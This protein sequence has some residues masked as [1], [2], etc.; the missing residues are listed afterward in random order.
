MVSEKLGN[1]AAKLARCSLNGILL[2]EISDWMPEYS[3]QCRSK[4]LSHMLI[5]P[6]S[7]WYVVA[8][9]LFVMPDWTQHFWFWWIDSWQNFLQNN[10]RYKTQKRAVVFKSLSRR[11]FTSWRVQHANQTY[12]FESLCWPNKNILS[13]HCSNNVTLRRSLY[14]NKHNLNQVLHEI[15]GPII[16]CDIGWRDK[17]LVRNVSTCLW[18]FA[19]RRETDFLE[20]AKKYWVQMLLL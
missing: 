19:S 14:T 17:N 7:C 3:T 13:S 11:H 16:I 10:G 4:H 15:S 6:T 5:F 1:T 18:R 20:R 12:S 8:W 2:E 9:W